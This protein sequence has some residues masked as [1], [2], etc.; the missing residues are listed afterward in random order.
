MRK[1]N[2]SLSLKTLE[3]KGFLKSIE[4]QTLL[5]IGDVMLDSYVMGKVERIS[6]EAPIPIVSVQSKESRLGGAANVAMNLKSL[7]ANPMICSVIGEDAAGKEFL[8]IMKE[9][10]L[11]T[12]FVLESNLRPTTIKTRILSNHQQLLRID[13]EVTHNLNEKIEQAFLLSIK[14]AITKEKPR[15]IIIQDYDKGIN[16]PVVIEEVT[17]LANE[18]QIPVLVDPKR[19]NFFRYKNV[20]HFKPNLK[21][22]KEGLKI[23]SWNEELS[24]LHQHCLR[25]MKQQE[26]ERM[27]V[28]MSDKGIF[29]CTAD[30]HFYFPAHIIHIADVSGAGDTVISVLALAAILNLDLYTSTK[31]A[32]LAGAIVCTRAG[33]VP[34]SPNDLIK[35]WV[36]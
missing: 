28:T 31:L 33:V 20:N 18:Y 4:D 17:D 7:G 27:T 25:F 26:I 5:V 8:S 11:D 9:N 21:E 3:L 34:I 16:T 19:K 10:K 32:N 36:H 23:D 13:E 14:D 22:L 6:P 1:I 2:K 24:G 15:A 30:E 35:Q 29:S 12:R